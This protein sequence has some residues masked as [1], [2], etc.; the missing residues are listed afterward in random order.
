MQLHVTLGIPLVG[1]AGTSSPP[2]LVL[3]VAP[4]LGNCYA[5]AKKDPKR[6]PVAHVRSINF[7]E[8]ESRHHE[9]FVLFFSREKGS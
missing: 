4:M 2:F 7:V 5:A 8:T 6:F 9:L 1:K 3:G